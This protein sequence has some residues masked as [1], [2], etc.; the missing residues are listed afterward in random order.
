MRAAWPVLCAV[1]LAAVTT[2]SAGR[3]QEFGSPHKGP[4]CD[5]CTVQA[6]F[7]QKVRDSGSS[8]EFL[9][10]KNGIGILY[11]T[12][13]PRNVTRLQRAAEWARS[14]L[15][16]ISEAP[17]GYHLCSYCKASLAVFSKVNREVVRTSQGALFLMRSD[18]P[19]A[20]RALRQQMAK[21]QQGN[22]L[23]PP[24]PSR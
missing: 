19:D 23:A 16:R 15:Q 17:E 4:D 9:E 13:D 14:E 6:T 10:L 21:Y 2:A 8:M 3:I 18:D 20:V 11:S 1:S 12:N 22:T 7:A 24:A 5:R